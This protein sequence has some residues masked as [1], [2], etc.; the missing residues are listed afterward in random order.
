VFDVQGVAHFVADDVCI[1]A[2]TKPPLKN[3]LKW[4]GVPLLRHGENKYFSE[5]SVQDFLMPLAEKD[6]QANRLLI[7]IRN[8][9]LR[10][11]DKQR[12][13]EKLYG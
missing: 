1:A 5:S 10:K 13:Q 8:N 11:L 12:D 7:L 3:A 6:Y 2:G 9:V 4:G